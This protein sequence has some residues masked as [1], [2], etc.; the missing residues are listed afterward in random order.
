MRPLAMRVPLSGGEEEGNIK[1]ILSMRIQ[2]MSMMH[3]IFIL[4]VVWPHGFFDDI[5]LLKVRT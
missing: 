5:W 3:N 1:N 4:Y 2:S